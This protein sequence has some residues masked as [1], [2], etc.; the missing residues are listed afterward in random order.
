MP[1]RALALISLCSL[2][3]VACGPRSSGSSTTSVPVGE[4][5]GLAFVPPDAIYVVATTRVDQ[6]AILLRDVADGLGPLVSEDAA[7]MGAELARALGFDPMSPDGLAEQG[8]DLTRGL[9]LWAHGGVGPTLALPLADP[10]RMVARI[11]QYRGA[12][13]AVVQVSRIGDQ[14][15]STWR[16]DR[17][18]AFHW[19]FVGDWLLVHL[20]LAVDAEPADAWLTAALAARGRFAAEPDFLAARA[21][22]AKLLAAPA[23][24]GLV[25]MPAILAQV[26]AAERLKCAGTLGQAQRLFLAASSDATVAQAGLVVELPSTDGVRAMQLAPPPGWVATRGEP[27]LVV[28][29]GL[30]LRAVQ[31]ALAPC[32]GTELTRD[33]IS[34]GVFGGRAFARRLEVGKLELEGAIAA[35]VDPAVVADA[36]DEIPGFDFLKRTRTVAGQAVVDVDVPMI[37]SFSY[38]QRGEAVVVT[39]GTAIDPILAGAAVADPP[40]ELARVELRPRAWSEDAWDSLLRGIIARSGARARTI[41]GL[42][43][44]QLGVIEAHRDGAAI[45]VTARG[46]RAR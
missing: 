27:P 11:E 15:V 16:P 25:R 12:G 43:R 8:V 21:A 30:D 35:L 26:P 4:H 42:R 10:A 31:A 38:A 29:L 23:V 14:E 28:E 24:V 44:W 18:L 9:A 3:L 19:A 41:A 34:G 46:E 32:I 22:A 6:V 40:A 7:T 2:V 37:P 36:L 33:A 17:D 20:E 1:R 13:G 5:A 45:V 39:V